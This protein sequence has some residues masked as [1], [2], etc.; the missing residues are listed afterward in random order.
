M[1]KG[2][3]KLKVSL[4]EECVMNIFIH[5]GMPDQVKEETAFILRKYLSE[6]LARVEV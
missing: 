1:R 3:R 2:E 5:L 6:P 4:S